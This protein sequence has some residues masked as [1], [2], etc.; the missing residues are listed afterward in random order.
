VPVTT[1]QQI[2]GR[3]WGDPPADGSC[4]VR[5]CTLLR[6][7]P[8]AEFSVEDLRIML[9]QGVGVP[10]L[11]P[12]AVDVLVADPRAGGDLY[13]GDL[14]ETVLRLPAAEWRAIPA[15]RARLAAALNGAAGSGPSV[16]PED[17]LHNV[18]E[19]VEERADRRLEGV[20]HGLG[21]E[22]HEHDEKDDGQ[23]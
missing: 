14:L 11:L 7:K 13:P 16:D 1:I 6:R 5:R 22:D 19:D 20:R 17:G 18:D 2:E 12:L 8:L 15:Q 21:I 4:L 10:V 3:D 9:A 23:N